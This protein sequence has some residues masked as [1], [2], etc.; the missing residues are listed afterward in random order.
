MKHTSTEVPLQALQEGQ[1]PVEEL[2]LLHLR[3]KE[4]NLVEAGGNRPILL[5]DPEISWVVY[6]GH[7]DIFAVRL[8]QGEASGV[9]THLFRVSAGQAVFG[10][11]QQST[12]PPIALLA[13]GGNQTRVLQVR[14]Q[15]LQALAREADFR[16]PLAAMVDHWVQG[17][18]NALTHDVPPKESL[19]LEPQT[20]L[21]VPESGS[22]SARR[23][24]LW[25]Q[26][27]EG[28]SSFMGD[29]T[30][31]ALNGAGRWPV[32]SRSWVQALTHSQLQAITTDHF[33][34]NSPAWY[35]IELFNQTILKRI[36]QQ[37]EK[38]EAAEAKQLHQQ[39]ANDQTLVQQALNRLASPLAR[40][41]ALGA[42]PRRAEDP[43]L[44]ACQL[45]GEYLGLTIVKPNHR[46]QSA[47]NSNHQLD[48][49][50]RSSH[51]QKRPVRLRGGWHQADNGPLLAFIAEDGR[52]VALLPT[53]PTA[54]ALH[55]PTIGTVTPVTA[56]VA[57]TLSP[58]AYMFYRS[59]PA[60][61]ITLFDLLRF[62]LRFSW[63]DLR[64]LILSNLGIT[65]LGL[66]IPVATGYIFDQVLPVTDHTTLWMMCLGLTVAAIATGL[67]RVAQNIAT[68]R[69]QGRLGSDI[70]AAVWDRL[71]GLPVAFFRQYT[72][73][74]L[75]GRAMGVS[76]IQQT[77]SGSVI[78][79][80]LSGVFSILSFFLLYT[81]SPTLAW[82]AGGLVIIAVGATIL[83]GYAQMPYAR[84]MAEMQ[85]RI[86]GLV[87]QLLAGLPKFRAAGA[88]GRAFAA[89]A[90]EFSA[91]KRLTYASRNLSNRL[92]VFHA[93]Y[94]VIASM[95]LFGMVAWSSQA[96]LST[97]DFLAFNVAFG[98]FLSAV[99]TLGSVVVNTLNILPAYERAQPILHSAPEVDEQK[100]PPGELTGQIQISRVTF[101][102]SENSPPVLQ[103]VSLE[104]EPGEFVALVG[105]SGSGKSTLLRLLL[106]FE[107]PT[108]G[109]IY[110]DGHDLTQLDLRATR[111][112]IGVVLQNGKLIGGSIF[113]NIVGA[114]GLTL[115]AAW[116]AA[117]MAGLAEDIKQMPMGMH[118]VI[119][120]GGSTLSGGQR[121]RLLIARAIVNRP[122][123]LYFDEA[124]SA[125][126]NRTQAMVSESLES[127]QATRLVVAHRLSTIEHADKIFVMENGR[128]VQ[129]G[130]YTDLIKQPGLFADL[131]RRQTA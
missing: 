114:L 130:K 87:L 97:G 76:A 39:L 27:L 35:S 111:R 18:S 119:T 77:L 63:S 127:L 122:R 104:I 78:S 15:R 57:S 8:H 37:L 48:L 101:R 46:N 124:T 9:R 20:P 117:E 1:L 129:S 54:Y 34:Q 13:V 33:I 47:A 36:A 107:T 121:Q 26:H 99:L 123:I 7:L 100:E 50:A 10:I 44:S 61:A 14:T 53:S 75:G 69:L 94:H 55:D 98:Q 109:A 81:Y 49:I 31:P 83:A 93:G 84:Q 40:Q 105:P 112:Q 90:E 23:G 118:T 120:D 125:L 74:D 82:V 88:E 38:A 102:Y 106:G 85:G 30:M 24:V 42:S 92:V 126:D 21:E 73:G 56:T 16:L 96:Q 67:L 59:F 65:L 5:T 115:K 43:L 60:R 22:V 51:W 4:A 113:I 128:I 68:L 80:S 19:K 71:M 131:A 3:Y 110:Y 116:N 70:Q 95:T 28:K 79:A 62:G 66:L 64:L 25:V 89:W 11:S 2:F 17:L 41:T 12:L 91:L 72:A 103:D 58:V 32:S 45:V 86:S 108:S 6:T 29:A 52:P